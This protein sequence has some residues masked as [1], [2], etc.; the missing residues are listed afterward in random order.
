MLNSTSIIGRLGSDPEVNTGNGQ[1]S[2]TFS[3]AV[4][5][6][7]KVNDE[8]CKQTH[9]IPCICFGR[10]AQIAGE[11][12]RK[13]VQAGVRGQLKQRQITNSTGHK[14]NKI[15]VNVLELEFLSSRPI[16]DANAE[17]VSH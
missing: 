10:L 6:F 3:L 2:T 11:F 4:N 13:G 15:E 17:V 9:W 1:V 12:L 8:L 14:I 7:Y 5:E 16:T